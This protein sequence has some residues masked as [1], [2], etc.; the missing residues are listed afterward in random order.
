MESRP[1]TIEY[2]GQANF[3]FTPHD[4]QTSSTIDAGSNQGRVVDDHDA[5]TSQGIR[6]AVDDHDATTSQ[7]VLRV[8][9]DHDATTS[10]GVLRVV[11]DPHVEKASFFT[12][13]K[14]FFTKQSPDPLDGIY[15]LDKK[16]FQQ[17]ECM[18]HN[19][20]AHPNPGFNLFARL[21]EQTAISQIISLK[22]HSHTSKCKF[23]Y[24]E[25]RVLF[26]DSGNVDSTHCS[27]E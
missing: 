7:G 14:K 21:E 3:K 11:D 25:L 1:G 15:E 6:R 24:M 22:F 19:H 27:H 26:L 17:L 20:P 5:T 2:I 8:V 4:S 13:I 12:K 23:T 18:S 16:E 9:D 10:Q